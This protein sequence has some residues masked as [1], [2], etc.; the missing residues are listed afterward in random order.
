VPQLIG[1]PLCGAESDRRAATLV[2]KLPV[3]EWEW[4]YAIYSRLDTGTG[5][6][7]YDRSVIDFKPGKGANFTLLVGDYKPR[8]IERG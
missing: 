1:G 4:R 5:E 6:W 3:S 8:G 2:I 7:K